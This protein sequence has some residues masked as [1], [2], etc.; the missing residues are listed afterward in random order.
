[1]TE[2]T[3]S[4]TVHKFPQPLENDAETEKFLNAPTAGVNVEVAVAVGVP[5]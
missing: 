2:E 5:V 1:M 4:G 3:P